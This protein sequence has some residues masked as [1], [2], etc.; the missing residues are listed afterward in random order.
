MSN[1]IKTEICAD[2]NIQKRCFCT[3][4]KGHSRKHIAIGI[5]GQFCNEWKQKKHTNQLVKK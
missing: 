2:I 3:L 4:K 5:A 1:K